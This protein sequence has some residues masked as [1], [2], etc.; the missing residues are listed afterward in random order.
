[1]GGY[2][3]G[4]SDRGPWYKNGLCFTCTQ[5]GDCC[6]GDPGMV[7]VD[8]QEIDEIADYLGKS[9]SQMRSDH[10]RPMGSRLSL[11]ER[12]DGD[13]T[14][15]DGET[16]RCLIYPVR[17]RQCRSWPFWRSNL[18]SPAA[19]KEAERICPG[20]GIGELVT[21]EEIEAKAE[22]IDI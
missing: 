7:V 15:L 22:L 19:W 10:V 12:E 5:C 8:D 4:M 20:A 6:S 18:K 14:F 9:S 11:T 16:R 17:P 2:T 3:L 13:C 21:L 1:M